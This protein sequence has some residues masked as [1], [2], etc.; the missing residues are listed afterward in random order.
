MDSTL[1][2]IWEEV[3]MA[4]MTSIYLSFTKFYFEEKLGFLEKK[5]CFGETCLESCLHAHF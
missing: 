5:N 3:T 2:Y 4:V 1:G